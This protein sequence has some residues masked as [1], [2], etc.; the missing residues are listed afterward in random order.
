MHLALFRPEEG[1]KEL[2]IYRSAAELPPIPTILRGSEQPCELGVRLLPT[3]QL[4]NPSEVQ[5]NEVTC[6]HPSTWEAKE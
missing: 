4:K 2:D 3:A 6:P 5:R 1:W